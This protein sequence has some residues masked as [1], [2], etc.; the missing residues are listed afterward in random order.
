MSLF[1]DVKLFDYFQDLQSTVLL[2]SLL[3]LE[4]NLASLSNKQ[5]KLD[6]FANLHAMQVTCNNSECFKKLVIKSLLWTGA[7]RDSPGLIWRPILSSFLLR[8]N[9][10]SQIDDIFLFQVEEYFVDI[11]F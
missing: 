8:L 11:N 10:I 6:H 1:Y 9:Y 5:T 2:C 4:K 3:D 7:L